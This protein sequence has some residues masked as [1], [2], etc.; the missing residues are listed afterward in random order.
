MQ[1]NFNL[2]PF[3]KLERSLQF[4][5]SGNLERLDRMLYVKYILSGDLSTVEIPPLATMPTRQH[6][7]WLNTCFE[8]FIAI[9]HQTNY[10]E[11]NLSPAGHWNIYSFTDYRQGMEW[12]TAVTQLPFQIQIQD[13]CC[14]LTL[15][16]DLSSIITTDSALKVG[17]SAVVKI[18]RD[19]VTYW[20][21]TH[22]STKADFH[23]RESFSLDL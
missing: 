16:F 2:K 3:S 15:A 12:E 22:P 11:F 4:E 17:I 13:N 7:L 9:P 20:A 10:W 18:D 14:Q 5:L 21:L 19:L 23:Q 6:E 1:H 8:F